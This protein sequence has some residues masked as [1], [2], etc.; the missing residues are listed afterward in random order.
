MI[1]IQ[2]YVFGKILG[3]KFELA[4]NFKPFITNF[5]CIIF[6]IDPLYSIAGFSPSKTNESK[7]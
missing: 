2:F 5:F 4:A 6:F 1:Y 7:I 3:V